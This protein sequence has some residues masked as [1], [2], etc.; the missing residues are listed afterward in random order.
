[1][2][3]RAIPLLLIGALALAACRDSSTPIPPDSASLPMLGA[4]AVRGQVVPGRYIVVFKDHVAG[5]AGLAAT[6]V[7]ERRGKLDFIYESALKG[8]AAELSAADAA[9]LARDPN[10]AFI[11]P[12]RV[13]SALGTQTPTPSWGLDRVD[14]RSLPLDNSYSFGTNGSGVHIYIIDTGIR[15]THT[16]FGGRAVFGFDVFNDG[17]GH[18][19]CNG[20]GTHVAGTAGGSK[21]GIAKGATLVTVRVLDCGGLGL[22]S[23]VVAGINFVTKNAIKPAVVNMSLGGGLSGALNQAVTKSIAAGVTYSIAAGNSNADAC[24]VSPA[25]TAT[26]LTVGATDIA[27]ARASFSNLGSCV[28][29]FAPGVSIISDY[30]TNDSATNVLS[31]TSMAA[32]HVTGTGA[33]YLQNNPAATPANVAHALLTTATTGVVGNPGAGSPNRLLYTGVASGPVV[34]LP[35]SARFIVNCSGLVC[36]FDSSPSSDDRGITARSWVLGDGA[37]ATGP[38]VHHGYAAAGTYNVKLTVSDAGGHSNSITT[39]VT[40]PAPS[41]QKPVANFTY[42]CNGIDCT[43]DSITSTDDHGIVSRAWNFG[44]G[45]TGSGLAPSHRYLNLGNFNVTL[46]VTDVAGLKGTQTQQVPIGLP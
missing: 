42:F 23:W 15:L 36:D 20:H 2:I 16:D 6:M 34:D 13:V 39:P 12:D 27:D 45:K 14:Q 30:R 46:T 37:V 26:A 1:M 22:T 19:D 8:F 18:T 4:G 21:Y 10:V 7:S 44:D 28:D 41:N 40:L 31:G 11:E 43:F 35:P 32:P 9:E 38:K 24:Q 29:L 3:R 5:V 33:L 17:N 25:S